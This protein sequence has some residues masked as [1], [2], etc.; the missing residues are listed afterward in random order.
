MD[1]QGW[2]R[3][4]QHLDQQG[5]TSKNHTWVFTNLQQGVAKANGTSTFAV[6]GY[7]PA[8]LLP[9]SRTKKIV[10]IVQK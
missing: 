9:V 7:S 8:V 1:L 6:A 2:I 5:R 4:L 10:C 3:S